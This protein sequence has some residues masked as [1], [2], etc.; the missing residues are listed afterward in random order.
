[1]TTIRGNTMLQTANLKPGL[2]LRGLVASAGLAIALTACADE[3]AWDPSKATEEDFL[4]LQ[5]GDY[6]DRA[7]PYI[8]EY[9]D[10]A[11]TYDSQVPFDVKALVAGELTKED[12]VGFVST[13]EVDEDM[14]RYVNGKYD[15]D[16]KVLNDSDYARSLGYDDIYAY[17]SM[18]GND[19]TILLRQPAKSRDRHLTTDLNHNFTYHKPIYPG[20]TLYVVIDDAGVFD[21]TPP[22]GS[23]R[24]WMAVESHASIYNQDAE[25]VQEVIFRTTRGLRLWADESHVVEEP[26]M[27]DVWDAPD[28]KSRPAHYYTDEDWQT[29]KGIWANEKRQGATPLYWEDVKVGDEPA[30]TA[31]GPVFMSVQPQ[32]PWG[33]G[34]SGS[35]TLRHEIMNPGDYDITLVREENTGN[36]TTSNRDNHVLPTPGITMRPPMMAEPDEEE[37]IQSGELHK[38]VKE[39]RSILINYM[40]RDFAIRHIN[41]WMGDHGW[42]QNIR[43]SIMSPK[44]FERYEGY[45]DIP[46][47]QLSPRYLSLVPSMQ[48]KSVNIHGLTQDLAIVKSYVYDKYVVNGE[49]IVELAWWIENIEG[50]IWEEG[51][52]TVVLPTRM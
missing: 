26:T 41:N 24:R 46:Q 22:G 31:D 49:H 23:T 3:Q 6:S 13:I 40:G 39:S 1:M 33:A 47:F 11:E 17:I 29:I 19:D 10:L 9:F 18:F 44:A 15:P 12:V 42:L 32:M 43:W 8:H 28:W 4:V 16:N 36:Y 52:A 25:K 2:M 5:A 38:E 21:L 14:V 50:D 7:G 20:D 34:V 30:W 45:D 37:D 48:G 27:A 35:K 51:A